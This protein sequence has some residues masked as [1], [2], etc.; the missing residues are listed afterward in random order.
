M[1]MLMA[2]GGVDVKVSIQ[3][4]VAGFKEHMRGIID[5]IH[6]GHSQLHDH[7]IWQSDQQM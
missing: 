4:S 3:D 6:I 5:K 7:A 2:C 1:A